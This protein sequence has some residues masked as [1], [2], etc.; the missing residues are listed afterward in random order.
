MNNASEHKKEIENAI[1]DNMISAL[2]KEKITEEDMSII[3][4]YVLDHIDSATNYTTTTDF[5][6][7]ISTRWSIFEP[8]LVMEKAGMTKKIEKEVAEGV[9]IL[10]QHGKIEN[11]IKLAQSATQNTIQ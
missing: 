3:S 9:L 10:A 1:V 11:A 7:D 4:G 8:L 5:L 2:E 6:K